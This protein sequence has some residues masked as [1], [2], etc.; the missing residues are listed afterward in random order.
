MSA[1][2]DDIWTALRNIC[3]ESL[4]SLAKK[5]TTVWPHIH[6]R[7]GDSS[8]PAFPLGLWGSFAH[9]QLED[10]EGVDVSIDFKWGNQTVEVTADVAYESGKILSELPIQYIPLEDDG[11]LTEDKAYEIAMSVSKYVQV[12]WELIGKALHT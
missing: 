5:V 9:S 11:S 4:Q 6:F 3:E 2:R 10:Q 8:N 7:S 1:R 12:Q